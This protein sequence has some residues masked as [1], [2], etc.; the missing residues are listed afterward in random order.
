MV[1][2]LWISQYFEQMEELSVPVVE[3]PWHERM[4]MKYKYL[5]LV[6]SRL[7]FLLKSWKDINNLVFIKFWQ[8]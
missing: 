8:K 6:P 1:I 4:Y 2:R 7:K 3:C 5:N